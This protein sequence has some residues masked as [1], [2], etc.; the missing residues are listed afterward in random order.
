MLMSNAFL[1]ADVHCAC[2]SFFVLSHLPRTMP[3][4]IL[5]KY[6]EPSVFHIS[7]FICLS[8]CLLLSQKQ[9]LLRAFIFN[10]LCVFLNASSHLFSVSSG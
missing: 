5:L 4:F 8:V 3:S 2:G 7:G 1:S 10:L 6:I 9:S